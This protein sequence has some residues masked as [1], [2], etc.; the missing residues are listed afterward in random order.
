MFDKLLGERVIL[1]IRVIFYYPYT[2]TQRC[3]AANHSMADRLDQYSGPLT[4]AQVAAGINA[5]RKNAAR[6]VYDAKILADAERYA[7][8]LALS[9]LS[10]EESGKVS[11]LRELSYA[12]DPK[13]LK[14]AWRRYRSH[15]SKNAHWLA[16]D[17]IRKG[18]RQM[19]DFA[20][21]FDDRSD[22]TEIL[23]QL[24]QIALYTDCLGKSHWAIPEDVVDKD[25]TLS[26][27]QTAAVFAK[28]KETSVEEVELWVEIM[29]PVLRGPSPISW[30]KTA[31]QRWYEEAVRRGFIDPKDEVHR[32]FVYGES[33][34]DK[35]SK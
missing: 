1:G 25:L 22:H 20:P 8:A 5:A 3:S 28:G 32:Q 24:K 31:F 14:S 9:I 6:L 21:L 2:Y 7:S 11:I 35:G 10:I 13:A 18:A 34:T 16:T 29:G 15:R 27:I 23:D 19:S 4:L 26:L 17:L 30:I 12:Q 33:R